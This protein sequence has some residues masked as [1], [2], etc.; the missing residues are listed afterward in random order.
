[1]EF[2]EKVFRAVSS[3]KFQGVD[4]R[5][6]VASLEKSMKTSRSLILNAL[7]SLCGEGRLDL[8]EEDDTIAITTYTGTYQGRKNGGKFVQAID[9]KRLDV[10]EVKGLN[11][12]HGDKVKYSLYYEDG[13]PHAIVNDL[14]GRANNSIVGQV[15]KDVSPTNPADYQLVFVPHD[16][17]FGTSV[18]LRQTARAN[19]LVKHKCSANIS[20]SPDHLTFECVVDRDF[21]PAGD[22]ITENTVIAHNARF[23]EEFPRSVE[24]EAACLPTEVREKDRVGRVDFTHL[25]FVTIDPENCK[26][27]DDAVCCV[28]TENGYTLHV[29]IADVSHYVEPGSEIEREAMERALTAYLGDRS[30]PMFPKALSEGICSI[31]PGVD[32]LA[33]VATI[34]LDSDGNILDYSIDKGVI[35]S[36]RKLTYI[37]AQ[38]IHEEKEYEH[39]KKAD[40]KENIDLMYEVTDLLRAKRKAKHPIDVENH[41]QYFR[42]N[43]LGTKVERID[44]TSDQTSKSVIEESMLISNIVACDYANKNGLTI[45]YRIHEVPDPL[46]IEDLQAVLDDLGIDFVVSPDP[47]T[48]ADLVTKLKDHPLGQTLTSRVLR[49]LP[50]ARYSTLNLG[51]FGLQEDNYTH[52]TAPI[53]RL[54]DFLVHRIISDH[55][56]DPSIHRYTSE[57]KESLCEHSSE[58]ER[59]A[60]AANRESNDLLQTYWAEGKV[61]G[62]IVEATVFDITKDSL[63]L[64]IKNEQGLDMIRVAVPYKS[65]GGNVVCNKTHTECRTTNGDGRTFGLGD[66]M[67]VRLLEANIDDRRIYAEVVGK[68]QK[69]VMPRTV[70]FGSK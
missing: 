53:R 45:P 66:K 6:V 57:E 70:T 31:N 27:M 51:H 22:P 50:K 46:R 24:I 40:V 69:F 55:I 64:T 3:R 54:P 4:F 44:D 34:N 65:L 12:L 2:K 18:P 21:G 17:R 1:M 8:V 67:K 41:E 35:H 14:I 15:L 29:A 36:R 10:D 61:I 52:F 56:M 63:I 25:D 30:Y 33:M 42:F 60:D 38:N 58:R 11:L 20:Y 5:E 62:S 37:E 9:G 26:D 43:S 59:T 49:A 39:I 48:I 7:D 16:R 23:K 68:V 13:R 28:R 47:V 19:A 32:R